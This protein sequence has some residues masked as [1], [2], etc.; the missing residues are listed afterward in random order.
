MA[1]SIGLTGDLDDV[2]ILRGVEE[3]FGIKVT[4]REA[5]QTLTVGQLYD[6]IESKTGGK[7][8]VC[9]SQLAFYRLRRAFR[10]LGIAAAV[11][12]AT[13]VSVVRTI[14]PHSIRAN[15]KALTRQSG[16]ELPALEAP[17]LFGPVSLPKWPTIAVFC[18]LWLATL[19][20]WLDVLGLPL[21]M[22]FVLL[23]AM[24][25]LVT[26]LDYLRWRIV[27]DIPRRLATVGDLAREAAGHSFGELSRGRKTGPSDRWFALLAG[28]RQ[29]SGYQPKIARD[30]T[31][32][33]Q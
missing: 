9:L 10:E 25:S 27:G 28:L 33:A 3:L 31:F 18:A 2:E 30:T 11:T 22:L 5:E 16:L 12:P 15:W 1:D 17:C 23:F 21:W 13:P 20:V 19:V 32:F 24:I 29:I 4:D 8:D 26:V 14:Q 7:T 6:L